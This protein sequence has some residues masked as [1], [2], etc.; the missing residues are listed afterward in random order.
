ML[1]VWSNAALPIQRYVR[2]RCER[3]LLEQC[4]VARGEAQLVW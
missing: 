2:I 1:P 3:A 4:E